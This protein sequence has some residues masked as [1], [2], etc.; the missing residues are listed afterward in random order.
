M[1]VYETVRAEHDQLSSCFFSADGFHAPIT[2]TVIGFIGS[3][4]GHKQHLERVLL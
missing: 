4:I 3:A 2:S 1:G